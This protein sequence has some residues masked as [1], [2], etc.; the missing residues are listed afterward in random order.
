MRASNLPIVGELLESGAEDRVFD[1]LLFVGPLLILF[2]ALVGRSTL[3]TG[4][5]VSY[6]IFFTAYVLYRGVR[7]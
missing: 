2:I 5:A 1:S 4:L 3:T 7:N 6:V